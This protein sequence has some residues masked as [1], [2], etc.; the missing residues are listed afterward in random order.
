MNLSGW[1]EYACVH[2]MIKAHAMAYHI[3]NDEFR[4][5][6]NGQVGIVMACFQHYSKN[7]ND[8]KSADTAFEFECGWPANPIFSKEGDYPKIMKQ[9]LE[10]QSK[11][12][13]RRKSKLPTFSKEW[14][15]YI[16]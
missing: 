10:E 16:K 12:E 7:K 5:K 2:N 4:S 14:I 6:Q 13:G 11:L 3:Y 15:D 9:M 8:L 1:G